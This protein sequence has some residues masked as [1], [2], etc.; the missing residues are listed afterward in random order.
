ME[1]RRKLLNSLLGKIGQKSVSVAVEQM[2]NEGL[3]NRKAIEQLYI[4]KE[5]EHRVRTGETKTRAIAQLAEELGCSYE[6][7]RAA[8]YQK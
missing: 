8:V 1:N 6:K 3:L 5:V 7:I 2:W 4:A